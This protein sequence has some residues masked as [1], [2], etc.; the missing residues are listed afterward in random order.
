MIL[1]PAPGLPVEQR[2][3][4]IL[5]LLERDKRVEVSDL[6]EAF[7][8]AE[9]TIRRDLRTLEQGGRLT[10][11]HGGAILQTSLVDDFPALT[12]ATAP[13]LDLARAALAY[14]P[15]VGSIFIDSGEACQ[16]LAAMLPDTAGLQV[17]TNAVPVALSASRKE[18]V[19]VY[20]LGGAVGDDGE[21]SGQWTREALASV[22]VDVAFLSCTGVDAAGSLTASTPRAAAIKRAAFDAATTRVALVHGDHPANGLVTFATLSDFTAVFADPPLSA[23]VESTIRE[24][25]I[26]FRAID[27]RTTKQ[28]E[29]GPS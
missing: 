2:H 27:T 21:Q 13:Q 18:H 14:V 6:A 26:D 22:R 5:S 25:G 1:A 24:A 7:A 17:V 15:E 29:E 16:S 11:A 9:E 19:A 4:V 3:A 10:R 12:G 8:V 23:A 20:N 28:E